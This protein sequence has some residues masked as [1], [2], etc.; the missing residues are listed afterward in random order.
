LKDLP[1]HV[2]PCVSDARLRR[3]AVD[4]G[5]R[6]LIFGKRLPGVGKS[7]GKGIVEFKKGLK[8]IEDDVEV[9]SSQPRRSAGRSFSS[10]RRVTSSIPT[11][12]AAL[13]RTP[14]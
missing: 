1:M 11:R 13:T 4:R 10:R 8:G 2:P 3:D 5:D 6:L 9:A 7:L 14:T 12:Q